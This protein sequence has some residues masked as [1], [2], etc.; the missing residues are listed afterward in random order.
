MS[1]L[2][3]RQ[4]SIPIIFVVPVI[5]LR[6]LGPVVATPALEAFPLP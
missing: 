6:P 5:V 3:H 4:V 2:H 1:L